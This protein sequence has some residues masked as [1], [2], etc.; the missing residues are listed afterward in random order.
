VNA[1]LPG[2]IENNDYANLQ[3]EDHQQH[4]LQ[5]VGKH[6]DIARACLF[7]ADKENNFITDSKLVIDSGM[8]RK[9]IYEE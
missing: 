2:G 1:I 9:M 4:F 7:L 3:L 8:T 6:E 5:R